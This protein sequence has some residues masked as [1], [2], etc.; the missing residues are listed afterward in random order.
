MHLL[1]AD[2]LPEQTITEL[3]S[4]GHTCVMEPKLSGDE[5]AQRIV[6]FDG[7]VVRSTKVKKP[8]FEAADRL[9]LVVRAGA[10]TNTIDTDAAATHG[11][12]VC[13]VPGRNAAAVAELTMGL[14]LAIDRRIA[15]N[16][17]DLRNGQWDKDRYSKA[18]GLLGS[19]MAVLG[20]GSIGLLV[21]ERAAAFGIK[22]QALA[23]TGRSAEAVARAEE[24]GITWCDSLEELLHTAD[25]VSLHVPSKAATKNLVD[26]HFLEQ[27]KP[28]AI[29]L[30]TSRGDV[31]DEA[32]LLEALESGAVRAGLDVFADEPGL[33]AHRV[34]LAAGA[35]PRGRRDPP[36]RRLDRAGAARD[37]RG[38]HRDHRRVHDRRGA[39]LRQPRRPHPRLVHAHHPPPR[40]GRRARRGAR[41]A[42][43]RPP[44]RRAHAEPDLPRRRGR[45]RHHRRRPPA[46]TGGA[47]G[48][49]RRTARAQRDRD[50]GSVSLVR[51]FPARV[52]R[53]EWAQRLVTGL[54][55][56]PEDTGTLP[57]VAPPDPTAYDE[58]ETALHLYRQGDHTGIVCEVAV[59]AFVDGRVRG[60]E[61]VQPQRV[62]SLVKHMETDAAPA[63]VALLHHAGPVFTRT[64]DE[65]TAT[66]PM[67]DFRGPAGLRQQ[68][69]RVPASLGA[70]L[71]A[72]LSA[73]DHYIADGHHRVAASLAAWEQHD[74]PDESSVLCVVH[75]MDG[76]RLSAFH[77]RVIGPVSRDE[78]VALL[79]PSFTVT[80]LDAAPRAEPGC[81]GLYAE[82]RWYVVTPRTATDGLDVE[83]LK[84]EVLDRQDRPI[85]IAPAK[86]QV[87]ELTRRCDADGGVLFTLAPPP[88]A[89]LTRLAD[90]GGVMPPKT[91]Y[92]EP[93]PCAGIF[94]R[95]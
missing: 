24:A 61:A 71:A 28:G 18:N 90:S 41:H 27:L 50:R 81:Y 83:V 39:P 66:E 38:R 62:D 51:P 34:V 89:A 23:K 17:A 49:A 22:V 80:P 6:G 7:L 73:A 58:P 33:R 52:V 68:V 56:L 30:N 46:L 82:R 88:L 10:G 85:E 31:V 5:L 79:T 47:R 26:A 43:Q 29:L 60:H 95:P 11:V 93:K 65:L 45:R 15:D 72:E 12:F 91:T 20:L 8:V 63:L 77:R 2:R 21:A 44:Q 16:V 64:V 59:R 84:T 69:W 92:F 54:A 25:I 75:P 74:R 14:L 9:A 48:A 1:F 70:F 87:D 37:R 35:A 94:R 76:L 53:A 40:P 42:Q 57:P 86:T 67:L 55:E 36:H 3:E 19:T 4:R 32:A 78:L 13:N